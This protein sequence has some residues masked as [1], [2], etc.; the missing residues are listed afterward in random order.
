MKNWIIRILL[1]MG[2]SIPYVFLA[3]YADCFCGDLFEFKLYGG[4][5]VS[6]LWGI[7]LNYGT[8]L[9]C[10]LLLCLFALKTANGKFII[11]GNTL[12][13]LFSGL[14]VLQNNTERWQWFF[15]PFTEVSFLIIL[16][17]V[18]ILAQMLFVYFYHKKQKSK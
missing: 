12:S 6:A 14:F 9:L 3:M 2:F 5:N 13:F 1:L 15:E 7:L 8:M 17:V 4:I 16:S 18:S 10:F 11:I